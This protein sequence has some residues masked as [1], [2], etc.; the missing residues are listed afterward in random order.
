M[1]AGQYVYR[2]GRLDLHF[3][4]SA[5]AP[6][7]RITTYRYRGYAKGNELDRLANC[8]I[9]DAAVAAPHRTSRYAALAQFSS[10]RH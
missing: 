1:P 6:D 2:Y 9:P 10:V 8:A 7:G 4:K 5:L 3:Q